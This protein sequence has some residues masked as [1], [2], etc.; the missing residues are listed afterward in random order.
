MA[1][2]A[3]PGVKEALG[4]SHPL[5]LSLQREIPNSYQRKD[6][7]SLITLPSGLHRDL[8][9][10]RAVSALLNP[11]TS[12]ARPTLA[13]NFHKHPSSPTDNIL[14]PGAQSDW[15]PLDMPN[16]ALL[17]VC[18]PPSVAKAALLPRVKG[19][20]AN[21]GM[22]ASWCIVSQGGTDDSAKSL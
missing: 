21:N 8:A 13:C 3:F 4:M 15:K 22:S 6:R 16:V 20:C 12:V 11:Q 9:W 7:P 19:C 14:R 17:V 10:T 5:S 1:E 18:V 2:R